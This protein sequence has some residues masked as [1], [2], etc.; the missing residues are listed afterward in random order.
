MNYDQ[1]SLIRELLELDKE[2]IRNE[3]S[4]ALSY[5][6]RKEDPDGEAS[7]IIFANRDKRLSFLKDCD[8]TLFE[9]VQGWV[10]QTHPKNKELLKFWQ[11]E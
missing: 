1:F 2:R 6:P 7:K 4:I 11:V 3:A 8:T 9:C 10:K 5:V